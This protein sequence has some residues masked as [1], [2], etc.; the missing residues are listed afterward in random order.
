MVENI[1]K[2]EAL[3]D[4]KYDIRETLIISSV[5]SI[6]LERFKKYAI[7]TVDHF[8]ASEFKKNVNDKLTMSREEEFK[9][10][11]HKYGNLNSGNHSCKDFRTCTYFFLDM[12]FMSQ[13]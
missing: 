5:F 12:G 1:P 6:I 9:K 13:E 10:L 8:F 11:I 2:I 3:I 4:G 7:S